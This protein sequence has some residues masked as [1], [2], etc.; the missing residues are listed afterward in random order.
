MVGNASQRRTGKQ[1]HA[2]IRMSVF[3]S[4]RFGLNRQCRSMPMAEYLQTNPVILPE[5]RS[6]AL[7]RD[8]EQMLLQARRCKGSA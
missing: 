7:Y 4:G 3:P 6:S 8:G 5:Q 1:T 2:D